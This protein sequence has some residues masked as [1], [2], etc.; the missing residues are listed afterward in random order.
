VA[1]YL[2]VNVFFAIG[3][4][5]AGPDS[6]SGP[7]PLGPFGRAFFFSVET[8]GTIGYGNIAPQ[9]TA[10]HVILSIEALAGLLAVALIT[11]IVFARFSRPVP[12]IAFSHR[13]LIAPY[14]GGRALM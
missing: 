14:R 4:F 7:V 2:A 6:L 5:L 13:A 10:A 1:T 3:F 12:K 9:N 11:G 8:F